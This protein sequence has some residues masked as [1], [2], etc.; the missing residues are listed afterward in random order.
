MSCHAVHN[1]KPLHVKK[2]PSSDGLLVCLRKGST[3]RLYE[4]SSEIDVAC[5]MVSLLS[6]C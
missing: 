3:Q 6:T 4:L 2:H 1:P 5:T